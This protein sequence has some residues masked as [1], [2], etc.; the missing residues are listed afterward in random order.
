[1]CAL[2]ENFIAVAHVLNVMALN[3]ICLVVLF[4]IETG[5]I[6]C[7]QAWTACPGESQT[8][9][10]GAEANER[11]LF[12]LPTAGEMGDFSCPQ[13]PIFPFSAGWAFIKREGKAE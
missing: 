11:S 3:R 6:T 10:T 8:H 12:Q 5:K 2:L 4:G 7:A 13:K 9:K 1:M